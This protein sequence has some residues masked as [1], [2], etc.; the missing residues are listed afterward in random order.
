MYKSNKN[1]IVYGNN[2]PK[3]CQYELFI[4]VPPPQIF[5]LFLQ[6]CSRLYLS[7]YRFWFEIDILQAR[8]IIEPQWGFFCFT[9]YVLY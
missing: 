9:I 8:E 1:I 4:N 3:H 7:I 5:L 2:C 6:K